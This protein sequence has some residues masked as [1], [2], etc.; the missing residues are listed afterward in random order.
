MLNQL[1][2]RGLNPD[3]VF[4]ILAVLPP[5]HLSAVLK[6]YMHGEHKAWFQEQ[7]LSTQLYPLGQGIDASYPWTALLQT[8]GFRV[9]VPKP[10]SVVLI[11]IFTMTPGSL[12][13]CRRIM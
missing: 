13:L 7:F 6:N 4:E 10:I 11:S 12:S 5:E 2:S 9:A 3:V 1:P 8:V